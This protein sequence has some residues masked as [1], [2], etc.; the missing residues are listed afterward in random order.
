MT[1]SGTISFQLPK[2]LHSQVLEREK[3]RNLSGKH[4]SENPALHEHAPGWNEN[5]ASASEATVKVYFN[6]LASTP[7]CSLVWLGGPGKRFGG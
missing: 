6:H 5:L 3:H 2:G 7:V 1:W 4:R